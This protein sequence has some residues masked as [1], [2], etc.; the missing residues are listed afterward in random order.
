M[1]YKLQRHVANEIAFTV[2]T[3]EDFVSARRHAEYLTEKQGY[4]IIGYHLTEVHNAPL[5]AE[6]FAAKPGSHAIFTISEAN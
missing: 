6:I 1:R 3:F 4:S 2:D 5:H